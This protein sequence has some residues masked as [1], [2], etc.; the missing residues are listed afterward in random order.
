MNSQFRDREM[1]W[2]HTLS[3]NTQSN[4]LLA[5]ESLISGTFLLSPPPAWVWL[6]LSDEAAAENEILRGGPSYR[7]E[8]FLRNRYQSWCKQG[9]GEPGGQ[10][11]LG[12]MTDGHCVA[13]GSFSFI[14]SEWGIPADC[15]PISS[16]GIEKDDWQLLQWVTMWKP[17]TFSQLFS[18]SLHK[19]L[20]SGPYVA[21]DR[22]I[23]RTPFLPQGPHSLGQETE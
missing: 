4:R 21:Q 16:T 15:H 13:K 7:K 2:S 17:K 5:A 19:Y 12:P 9:A 14:Y 22:E 18:H 11:L 23:N 20:L 3:P 6:T 10:I 1:P 8:A